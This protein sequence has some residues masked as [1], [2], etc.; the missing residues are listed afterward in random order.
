MHE[1][2][3]SGPALAAHLGIKPQGLTNMR[4][5]PNASMSALL[6]AHAAAF[7]RCDLY[8]LCTGEGGEYVAHKA[9]RRASRE[10]AE[11]L[12]GMSSDDAWKA[13][14]LVTQMARGFW[15]TFIDDDAS[16]PASLPD[17]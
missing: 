2:K 7:L 5:K 14:A 13:Y 17:R 1:A 4:R 15:P 12:E 10:A 9:Y 8:W 11:V 16:P 3:V 6:I